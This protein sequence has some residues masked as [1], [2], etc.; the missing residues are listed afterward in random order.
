M[1]INETNSC[2]QEQVKP[3]EE[4]CEKKNIFVSYQGCYHNLNPDSILWITSE[5]NYVHIY[6]KDKHYFNRISMASLL[7]LLP[8]HHFKKIHKCHLVRM[9]AVEYI[10]R[11]NSELVIAGKKIPI[12]RSYKANLL[13]QLNLIG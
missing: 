7:K 6:T 9:D 3:L 2:V 4:R 13:A 11:T 12:G 10:D 5:G 8:T 1:Q